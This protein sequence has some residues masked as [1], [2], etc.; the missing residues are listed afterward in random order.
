MAGSLPPGAE[1]EGARSTLLFF[2][3][4]LPRHYVDSGASLRSSLFKRLQ[5]QPGVVM[6]VTQRQ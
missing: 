5:G 2:R 4:H 1:V 3:G 6:E